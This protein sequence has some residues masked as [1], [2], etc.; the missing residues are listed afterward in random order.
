MTSESRDAI[1]RE[2]AAA[3]PIVLLIV[4]LCSIGCNASI[5]EQN[6]AQRPTGTTAEAIAE[7]EE[8]VPAAP[9]SE[10]APDVVLARLDGH[11][12]QASEFRAYLDRARA[13][14]YRP[15]SLIEAKR[16]LRAFLADQALVLE[17]ARRGD[18]REESASPGTEAAYYRSLTIELTGSAPLGETAAAASG[19][20]PS[21]THPDGLSTTPDPSTQTQSHASEYEESRRLARIQLDHRA[22]IQRRAV[23]ETLLDRAEVEIDVE[24]LAGFVAAPA[25]LAPPP[26]PPQLANR[27]GSNPS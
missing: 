3:V 1:P 13:P 2:F 14:G 6:S 18:D 23:L 8:S 9:A 17:S 11:P 21:T 7:E 25:S 22:R 4:L 27:P 15:I 16:L 10:S 24:Q 5:E 19:A 12:L 20:N 26:L